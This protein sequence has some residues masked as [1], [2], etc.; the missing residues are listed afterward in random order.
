MPLS[1]IREGLCTTG[2]QFIHPPPS[3][4]HLATIA[5]TKPVEDLLVLQE[6]CTHVFTNQGCSRNHD[7]VLIRSPSKPSIFIPG[8]SGPRIPGAAELILPI[9][10]IPCP[11]F[12]IGVILGL[13]WDNGKDNGNSY[14]GLYRGYRD[15]KAD[16]SRVPGHTVD[17]GNVAPPQVPKLLGITVV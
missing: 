5:I 13:Y 8:E 7:H 6:A 2:I 17:A 4:P 1:C 16:C 12:S 3:T 11:V 15:S 10:R 9:Q 14:N